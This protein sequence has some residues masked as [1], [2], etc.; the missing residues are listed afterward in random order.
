[1][2][3]T[4]LPN[5]GTRFTARLQLAMSILLLGAYFAGLPLP[6]RAAEPFGRGRLTGSINFGSGSAL[7]RHYTV[8]GGT[9]GYMAADGLMFAVSAEKWFGEEPD[10]IKLTPEM[11][12]TFTWVEP[13]KPYAGV[14]VSRTFYN[15][16]QDRNTYG[17][18][19]GV[20][21]PFSSNA[22]FG[23][24]LVYEKISGCH[25]STYRDCSQLYPEASVMFSF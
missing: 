21:W 7:D 6:G 22:A 19:G 20:Y 13:V 14:F 4:H 2:N 24:G 8:L 17:A 5:P 25:T 23:T 10:I 3:T 1:M 15:G 16:L 11:R 12:Y 18:R 9:L